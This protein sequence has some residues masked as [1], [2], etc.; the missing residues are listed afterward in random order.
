MK[1]MALIALVAQTAAVPIV[2]VW[3]KYPAEALPQVYPERSEGSDLLS[4][5][6]REKRLG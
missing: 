5:D 4:S 3:P 6:L 1:L 2:H